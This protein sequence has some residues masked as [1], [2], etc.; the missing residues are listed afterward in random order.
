MIV[1]ICEVAKPTEN[2]FINLRIVSCQIT[3][4]CVMLLLH[5]LLRNWVLRKLALSFLLSGERL[6]LSLIITFILKQVCLRLADSQKI[7]QYTF[8]L[9]DWAWGSAV[10]FWWILFRKRPVNQFSLLRRMLPRKWLALNNFNYWLCTISSFFFAL[11]S[12]YTNK[13][14]VDI[15]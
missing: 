4:A 12:N 15:F 1:Q 3:Q 5:G 7:D 6:L 10:D 13:F 9:I 14:L 8:L 11:G 2:P